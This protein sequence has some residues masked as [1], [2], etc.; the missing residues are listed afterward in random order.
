[1]HSILFRK[2]ELQTK[3]N[4]GMWSHIITVGDELRNG[5]DSDAGRARI[6]LTTRLVV[7]YLGSVGSLV[8]A[9]RTRTAMEVHFC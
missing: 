8:W 7:K 3:N 1:M 6:T 9:A 5:T 4:R 2:N